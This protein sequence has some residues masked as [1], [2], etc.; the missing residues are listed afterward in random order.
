MSGLDVYDLSQ[1]EIPTKLG[2]WSGAGLADVEVKTVKGKR[3]VYAASEYWF[4][5]STPPSVH[6]LDATKLGEIRERDDWSA[7]VP[8][9]AEWRVNGMELSGNRLQVAFSHVGL[10]TLDGTGYPKGVYQQPRSIN[11]D[12]SL[13]ASP[14][15][16]DVESARGLLFLSDAST[17]ILT[18]LRSR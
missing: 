11:K 17:G 14:Y 13:R 2:S 4:E 15:A 16:M 5:D 1:P 9:T 10:V 8:A 3:T 18:I 7:G 12:S 6:V